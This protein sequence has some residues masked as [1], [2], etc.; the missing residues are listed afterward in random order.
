MRSVS[1]DR[2]VCI[3]SLGVC[4]TCRIG[5][6]LHRRQ[7]PW[8]VNIHVHLLPVSTTFNRSRQSLCAEMASELRF[9]VRCG[10]RQKPVAK[11]RNSAAAGLSYGRRTG[12]CSTA[13]HEETTYIPSIEFPRLNGVSLVPHDGPARS[14][15]IGISEDNAKFTI[16][17]FDF[18]ISINYCKLQCSASA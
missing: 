16:F 7:S 3:V 5:V 18:R 6:C 14:I 2:L 17:S 8:P 13:E 4:C 10:S 9:A 12:F 1:Y 11:S 15:L